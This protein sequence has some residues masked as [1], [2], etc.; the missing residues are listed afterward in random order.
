M[1]RIGE[2]GEGKRGRERGLDEVNMSEMW[3]FVFFFVCYNSC[4]EQKFVGRVLG[5]VFIVISSI[6]FHLRPPPSPAP[7]RKMM[8]TRPQEIFDISDFKNRPP[9]FFLSE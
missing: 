3:D 4:E 7:T 6:L 9:P 1:K 5:D 8:N 2:E